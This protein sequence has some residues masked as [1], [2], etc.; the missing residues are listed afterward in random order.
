MLIRVTGDLFDEVLGDAVE[1]PADKM[2]L[3]IMAD[4]ARVAAKHQVYV[5][6]RVRG[7]IR[8]LTEELS[9]SR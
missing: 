4:A 5:L 3:Q 1:E 7:A 2:T 9:L 6:L 8:Y